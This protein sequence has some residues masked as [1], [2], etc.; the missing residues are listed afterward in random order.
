M[1][2]SNNKI[3]PMSFDSQRL[4][5]RLNNYLSMYSSD[6][7][8]KP[9][10]VDL[11]CESIQSYPFSVTY[12]TDLYK[13]TE[14]KKETILPVARYFGLESEYLDS[15]FN[16]DQ[17]RLGDRVGILPAGHEPLNRGGR[18]VAA[19]PRTPLPG[20]ENAVFPVHGERCGFGVDVRRKKQAANP[21]V[22][23]QGADTP[24]PGR[25]P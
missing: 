19:A 14:S 1:L 20:L 9:K 6:N 7:T 13:I 2:E 24:R 15:I 16:I 17:E 11:L 22:Q 3:R 10:L 5:A 18:A 25:F 8:I 23:V 21:A 12:Y 4:D